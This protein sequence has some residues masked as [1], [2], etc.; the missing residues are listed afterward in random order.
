[1]RDINELIGI[2]K[3]VGFDGI[4]N[5]AEI[6]KLKGWIENNKDLVC[7]KKQADLISCIEKIIKKILLMMRI[8]LT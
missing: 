4:I 3:G 2:V 8:E 1:M 7:D 6:L 5:Q